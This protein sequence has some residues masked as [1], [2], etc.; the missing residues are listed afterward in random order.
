MLQKTS[1]TDRHT[2]ETLPARNSTVAC[3]YF[4][5]LSQA[6]CSCSF[7]FFILFFS[8]VCYK[9]DCACNRFTMSI[10]A[11]LQEILFYLAIFSYDS[12]HLERIIVHLG[13][14]NKWNIIKAKKKIT[15]ILKWKKL[16]SK[17]EREQSGNR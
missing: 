8:F 15:K 1:A 3:C 14:I 5:K 2:H 6:C 10:F 13:Y 16:Q 9:Y 4:C 17:G 7:F 11:T 12:L